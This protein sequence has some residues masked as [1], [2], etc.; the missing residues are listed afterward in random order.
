[1]NS[2]V[3]LPRGDAWHVRVLC[4]LHLLEVYKLHKLLR[5]V[6]RR[7]H[8]FV[9]RHVGLLSASQ[10]ESL[11]L[12]GPRLRETLW[13]EDDRVDHTQVWWLVG[14]RTQWLVTL[15]NCIT[16]YLDR[17]LINHA[18]VGNWLADH[19]ELSEQKLPLNL[20]HPC[21]EC[22]F[23]FVADL[24]AEQADVQVV[25]ITV[26]ARHDGVG[27]VVWT[28]SYFPSFR[29]NWIWL[30]L[31]FLFWIA[32]RTQIRLPFVFPAIRVI[33]GLVL[34]HNVSS[35]HETTSNQLW[36]NISIFNRWLFLSPRW[37]LPWVP[38]LALLFL[39][40]RIEPIWSYFYYFAQIHLDFSPVFMVQ[41]DKLL[42]V[43]FVRVAG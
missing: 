32:Y 9:Y 20:L 18:D 26:V 23:L 24:V 12:A 19:V 35:P 11:L 33:P 3:H 2:V 43:D 38:L 25:W 5:V 16:V 17:L 40:L 30:Q 36:F 27:V 8:H 6:P 1:M 21:V 31:G 34:T 22:H 29:P 28:D 37:G 7:Q 14:W 10:V 4:W 42:Y 13:T 41:S 15:A 39:V